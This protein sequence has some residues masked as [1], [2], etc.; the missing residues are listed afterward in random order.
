MGCAVSRTI[1]GSACHHGSPG[2]PFSVWRWGGVAEEDF[3]C[4]VFKTPH[5]NFREAKNAQPAL[6]SCEEPAKAIYGERLGEHS[7]IVWAK[8]IQARITPG[9]ARTKDRPLRASAG[10]RRFSV[11]ISVMLIG[12]VLASLALGVLL[13]YGICQAMFRVFR[14]HAISAARERVQTPAVRTAVEG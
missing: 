9:S 7:S 2:L 3:H 10:L 14:V 5:L 4:R 11:M 8:L 6:L 12:A 13:A 1:K